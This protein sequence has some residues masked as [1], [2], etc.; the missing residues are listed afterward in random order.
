[1][2]ANMAFTNT[3]ILCYPARLPDPLPSHPTQ[4]TRNRASQPAHARAHLADTQGSERTRQG[5]RRARD[6]DRVGRGAQA[7]R[8]GQETAGRMQ[9][10]GGGLDDGGRG[11]HPA[12]AATALP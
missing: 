11:W 6:L 10:G 7:A 1:M 2:L 12:A 3:P 4:R 9:R 5:P 8:K